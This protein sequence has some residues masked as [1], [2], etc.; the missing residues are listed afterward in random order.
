M[1]DRYKPDLEIPRPHRQEAPRVDMR[2]IGKS[3]KRVE[4]P[5]LLTGSG[6]F[7]ADIML[8]GM[9]H[10]ALLRSPVAHA[11]IR[12]VDTS[13]ARALPGV[14][15]VVTGKEL[16]ETT[17]PGVSFAAPPVVQHVIAVD[18]VRHVG[19]AV[20]AVIA[21]SRYIAEDA[22]DLIEV[23]YDDLPVVTDPEAACHSSGDAVLHPERGD[24]NI[25]TEHKFKFGP[26]DEDFAKADHIVRRRVRWNR[27]GAQP[28]ETVGAVADYNRGTGK[29]TVYCN[30]AMVNF[31]I[32]FCAASLGVPSTH[33]NVITPL[34]GGSFGAKVFLQKAVIL[35]AAL[36]RVAGCPVKYIEDRHEHILNGDGHASDRIYDAELALKRDGT[37]LS[38]RYKVV[39]DYGAYMVFG[40]GSHGNTLAQITGPY[41]INSV[42]GHI[43]AVLTNKCQQSAFRGFGGE[44]SNFLL[45]RLVDAAARELRVDPVEIR[46]RNLI[47]YSEFP[48]LTP[49]GNVYDSGNYPEAL[50]K[51]L[52]LFDYEGWRKKQAAARAEGRHI[53]IGIVGCQE[54]SVFS[55]T[56][57][58]MLNDPK[59]PGFP[60]SSSP[61]SISIR[62]DPMG[63]TYVKLN[64]PFWGQS[65][66]TMVTQIVAEALTVQPGDIEINY[67]DMASGF[68]STGPGGSRFTT[69]V[70][71][72]CVKGVRT[73]R[74][75]LF[76]FAAH[77]LDCREEDLELRD[78]A[79]F[80]RNYTDRKVT[81][82]DVAM[83]SHYFRLN[84]PEDEAFTS[85]LETTAVYDHPLTTLPQ[86]EKNHMGIFYPMMGHAVHAVA[87]E[88]EKMTGKVHFLD[89]VAVHDHGTVVNPMTADGQ[90][91]GATVQAIGT[92][93]YEMFHYDGQG[94]MLNASFA[95]YHIPTIME[96]PVDIR[97]GHLE[98]PSPFTE[99]GIKGGG[100]GGRMAA[101]SAIVQA[102]E[103]A[104]APMG[105]EFMELPLPPNRIRQ[106]L[107]SASQ[108]TSATSVGE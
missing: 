29:F 82:S 69:M 99:Y 22:A 104:F 3:I 39:D 100:E 85:G 68:N 36:S 24:T 63:K 45:E 9:A 65:P 38:L 33:L 67:A 28:M 53:G 107:R 57:F 2:W 90:I 92:A 10:V 25:A 27:M 34:V 15:A 55:A 72:A 89:Y 31:A 4:D 96:A 98:T 105:V 95:D 88:V 103:D 80:V 37:I 44:V 75:K 7:V 108:E 52:E 51:A 73:L 62:I 8:P 41:R 35:A 101:P 84:F 32:G 49:T 97:I 48:Y 102:V 86:P 21:E 42:Q 16:A 50:K 94:Q 6:Q 18:R 74:A 78:G 106:I 64:A 70:A 79:I 61:E 13:A 66:E 77:M 43:V 5:K 40:I 11:R 87:L 83:A 46:R 26:V 23:E 14:I 1:A 17:G 76:K 56:E 59:A 19:E 71:G 12:S 54:R 93:L 20:A 30:T 81:I 58:W 47:Q 60:L 91:R